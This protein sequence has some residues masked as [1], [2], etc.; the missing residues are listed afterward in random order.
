[1]VTRHYYHMFTAGPTPQA[2]GGAGDAPPKAASPMGRGAKLLASVAGA[3]TGGA[4]AAPKPTG[5]GALLQRYNF[6]R[7]YLVNLA[8]E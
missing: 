6:W 2:S 3:Q 4:T 7:L 8:S 5:R 1:M